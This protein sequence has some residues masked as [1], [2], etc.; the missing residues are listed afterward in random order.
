MGL[1]MPTLSLLDILELLPEHTLLKR[2]RTSTVCN[3]ITLDSRRTTS[4]S[5]FVALCGIQVDARRFIE[6]CSAP[7]V[8]VDQWSGA[9]TEKASEWDKTIIK[10]SNA[11]RDMAVLASAFTDYPSQKMKMIGITGT[12]GKTTTTWMLSHILQHCG[13][14]QTSPFKIGTIGTIGPHINGDPLPNPDGFTTPESPGLQ[15]TLQQFVNN[16][17]GV[18]IMEVSSIGLMMQRVGNIQFDIAA[19][20]NFTQD[21][22]DIHQSMNVYLQE[23]RKLFTQHVHSNSVSI[24]VADQAETTNT[25]VAH[26][27]TIRLSTTDIS[28]DPASDGWVENP[29]FSIEGSTFMF[30][31]PGEA[32]TQDFYV[33]LIGRHNIENAIVAISIAVMM[34]YTSEAIAAAFKSL[35]QVPGRME[36]ISSAQGWHAFVDYAHTPDALEQSISSLKQLCTGKLWVLFGCGGDRDRRKRAQM[37]AIAYEHADG[38]WITS[39]NPRS[40]TPEQIIDDILT[41]LP[42]KCHKPVQHIVDRRVA[43]LSAAKSLND[44][45]VLLIAG[46]GHETYQIIDGIK[47]HFDDREEIRKYR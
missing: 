23:K 37:G 40:E 38:I 5:V 39:D 4:S 27:R 2:S 1:P 41:G 35:P 22:L 19:F 3:H 12:N 21:H 26:G 42:T 7:C 11:R 16:G 8:L 29:I 32:E 14:L 31:F 15:R 46:K 13:R 25:P 17:C 18:C 43:I 44:G 9:W 45:D 24:L 34:N 20:T 28:Q 36:R 30:E 10:V 47:Y 6:N 33:P